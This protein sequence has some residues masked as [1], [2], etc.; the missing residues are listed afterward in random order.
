[1]IPCLC[2]MTARRRQGIFDCG[3]FFFHNHTGD[4]SILMPLCVGQF[5]PHT[6][7]SSILIRGTIP[8]SCVG[9][10]H[11]HALVI[12]IFVFMISI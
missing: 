6:R 1:M 7:D 11:P 12:P 8:S 2:R 3:L 9:Q 5:H 10:F 4:I